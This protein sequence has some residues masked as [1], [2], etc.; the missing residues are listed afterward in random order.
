MR[1]AGAGQGQPAG[2]VALAL[3]AAL[4]L[5][6]TACSDDDADAPNTGTV[7]PGPAPQEPSEVGDGCGDLAGTDPSDLSADRVVARCGSG[8]PEARPLPARTPLRVAVPPQPGE[9]Q[10]PVLLARELGAFEDENLAVELVERDP[11][12]AMADLAAGRV[13]VVVGPLGGPFFDVVYDGS[14]ARVVLG[15]VLARAPNRLT[16]PQT[17]L[18]L[19]RNAISDDSDRDLSG[20]Q[21]QPVGLPGGAAG[22]ALY[23]I[24][25]LVEQRNADTENMSMVDVSGDE[26]A[27]QL[28]SGELAAAWLDGASWLSVAGDGRFELLA[29]LPATEAIDG[30]LFSRR[31]TTQDREVGLAYVRAVIRTINTD[32]SGDYQSDDGVVAALARATGL[33]E[34][35]I[36]DTRPLLFD[37]EIRDGTLSRIEDVLLTAGGV[38]YESPQPSEDLVDRSLAAEAVGASR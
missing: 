10:A 38:S 13:D 30:T 4:A 20:L 22:P 26:A 29:T 15:G 31:L 37:W 2:L 25:H 1:T 3:V 16:S 21:S 7:P 17:G 11:A 9:E 36:T 35:V 27:E 33:D 24:S 34:D 32:L 14:G 5:G 6:A 18:W 19:R 12:A 8:S 23:P 28:E